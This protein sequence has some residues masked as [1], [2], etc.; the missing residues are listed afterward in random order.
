MKIENNYQCRACQY[1]LSHPVDACPVC[2]MQFYW[3]VLPN[4]SLK[5]SQTADYVIKMERIVNGRVSHE[6][7]THG[8]YLWLPYN[9]WEFCPDGDMLHEFNWISQ[10]KFFQHEPS[11]KPAVD[12]AG[13]KEISPWETNPALPV[14][15]SADLPASPARSTAPPE[16]TAIRAEAG[17]KKPGG[18]RPKQPLTDGPAHR[19]WFAPLMVLIFLI[20]LSLSYLVLRYHK[21]TRTPT[22]VPTSKVVFDDYKILS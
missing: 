9:F 10:V 22:I 17:S 8:G 5:K 13:P 4:R 6:F 20:M 1:V 16:G 11:Q 3:M 7:L 18:L 21:N 12:A 14:F 15:N 2:T 19:D